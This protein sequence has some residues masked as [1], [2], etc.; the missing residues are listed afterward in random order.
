MTLR[1][2]I[3]AVVAL[4]LAAVSLAACSITPAQREA[5]ERAWSE[6]DRER[7]QECARIRCGQAAP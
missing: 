2:G 7:A 5:T 4:I 1:M 6:R 3:R